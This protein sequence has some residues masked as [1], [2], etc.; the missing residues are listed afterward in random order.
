[1]KKTEITLLS[2]VLLAAVLRF[3][4]IEGSVMLLT[5]CALVLALF[6]LLFSFLLFNGIPMKV[7]F[8]ADAYKQTNWKRI[9]GSVAAGFALFM[10]TIGVLFFLNRWEGKEVILKSG[11]LLLLPVACVSLGMRITKP[12]SYS[13]A[14][15]WR[16][17]I[18]MLFSIIL[19][20]LF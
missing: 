2:I 9:L 13:T 4:A 10:T 8:R 5:L 12:S 15:L 6:Y 1:M 16:C 3:C 14:M 17:G 18:A 19:L 7:M 11:L 20:L